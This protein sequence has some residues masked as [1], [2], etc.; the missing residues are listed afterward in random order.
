MPF[1]NEL[2]TFFYKNNKK[3]LW[4]TIGLY[5]LVIIIFLVQ[6]YLS[7]GYNAIDLAIYNQVFYNSAHGHLFQFSIHPHSYLG[8]HF[9][10][11]IILLLPFY[12]FFQ[13]PL[14]LLFLQTLFLG[15]AAWPLYLLARTILNRHWSLILAAAFL[16]NPFIWNMNFFEFHILP[17]AIFFLLFAFYHYKKNNFL[18]FCF[19]AGISLL[20]RE[21]VSLVI[22]MFGILALIEKRSLKWIL[23]PLLA[24]GI[25]FITA[26]QLT[27]YFNNYGSYKFLALYNWLGE[28]PAEIIKNLF[29]NPWLVLKNIFTFNNLFSVLGLLLPLAALPV[30]KLK[31]LLPAALI[32]IQLFLL[33]ASPTIMLETHYAA[34]IIPFLFI[35]AI[36]GLHRV[37]QSKNRSLLKKLPYFPSKTIYLTII[38]IAFLYSW[39]TFSPLITATRGFLFGQADNARQIIGDE[40]IKLI[41]NNESVV[42]SYAYL[43]PLSGRTQLYSLHYAFEGKK[44]YSDQ[45]YRIDQPIDKMI[46]DYHDFVIYYLQSQGHGVESL[47]YSTGAGRIAGL[48]EKN[49]LGLKKII[50]NTAVYEKNYAPTEKL[51]EELDVAPE[52]MIK[53]N[54]SEGENLIL[55]GWEYSN[56]ENLSG[57]QILP[58][59]LY[60]QAANKIA[61][62]YKLKISV[63]DEKN[64][65]VLEKF[66]PLGYGLLPTSQWPTDKIIQTNY[67]FAL[68]EKMN[69]ADHR[70]SLQTVRLEGYL[71][72]DNLRS[73]ETRITNQENIGEALALP[74]N[75]L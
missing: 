48:I 70:V 57:Y 45:A 28:T 8:D 3:I 63:T 6:K 65:V 39:V 21:D 53:I 11:F 59:S 19:I 1:I 37:L 40:Q 20:I 36:Y 29:L 64:K 32:W 74:H 54:Q 42:S 17:F 31:Y 9:E 22:L 60:W 58:L 12:Y 33:Q 61:D 15:L 62:D 23:T 34:L 43:A 46:V 73:A 5:V 72:L 7:Y 75:N 35:S 52:K 10:L 27:G 38:I 55:L 71:D 16:I 49:N 51:T 44:Q 56:A 68:P 67:W 41:D 14:T 69:L 4:T 66:Y 47:Q 30:F 18:Q 25:W 50:D 13:S 26:F 24:G 2:K